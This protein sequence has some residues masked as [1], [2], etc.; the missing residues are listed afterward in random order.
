MTMRMPQHKLDA[1]VKLC[2]KYTQ[3]SQTQISKKDL[4]SL[5]GKLAH[6]ARC[7]RMGRTFL[8]RLFDMLSSMHDFRDHH[9]KRFNSEARKD[10]LWWQYHAE[11]SNG[12]TLIPAAVAA[13]PMEC[14]TDACIVGGA[15]IFDGNWFYFDFD[16]NDTRPIAL[17][18]FEVV[19]LAL[20]TWGDAWQAKP[21]IFH[22]DNSNVVDTCNKRTSHSPQLM[23]YLR[24]FLLLAAKFSIPDFLFQFL[25]SKENYLADRLSRQDFSVVFQNQYR[26]NSSPSRIYPLQMKDF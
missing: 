6:L 15:A 23:K 25:P 20:Q 12:V 10:L 24:N 5:V 7:V 13:D 22:V 19:L 4:K 21:V 11:S 18:E 2:E 3:N 1:V 8:R 17:K 14:H 26:L 16:P 9:R